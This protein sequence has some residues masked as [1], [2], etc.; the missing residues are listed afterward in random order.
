MLILM[1]PMAFAELGHETEFSILVTQSG[2]LPDHMTVPLGAYV[3]F[4]NLGPEVE[5]QSS[6][7]ESGQLSTYD[8]ADVKMMET[9]SIKF[10]KSNKAEQV[11][12]ITVE[13]PNDLTGAKIWGFVNYS[14]GGPD[15]YNITELLK[16]SKGKEPLRISAIKEYLERHGLLT[17][18]KPKLTDE[19]IFAQETVIEEETSGTS[20]SIEESNAVTGTAVA[21]ETVEPEEYLDE[22]E[23]VTTQPQEVPVGGGFETPE[24]KSGWTWLVILLLL[25]VCV[26]VGV[27]FFLM[28]KTPAEKP[29]VDPRLIQYVKTY[30]GHGYS[31]EVLRKH[32]TS[33]GHT[34]EDIE[35]AFHH[36]R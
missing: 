7:Y 20:E 4:I 10:F 3:K 18:D 17:E 35:K 2:F 15:E 21:E 22:V 9:G 33:H 32:L 6:F 14:G 30:K 29:D 34:H 12:R 27:Y 5:I 8:Y 28:R 16:L 1:L 36:S 11:I 19:Q 24:K 31:E 26:G 13:R 23:P 25:G